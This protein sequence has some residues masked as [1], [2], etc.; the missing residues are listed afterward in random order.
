MIEQNYTV[1]LRLG[2]GEKLDDILATLGSVAEGGSFHP[3]T[4][5]QVY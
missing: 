1:G 3:V 2:K 4:I 5:T